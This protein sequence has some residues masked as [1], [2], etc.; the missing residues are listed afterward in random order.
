MDLKAQR[1]AKGFTQQEIAKAVGISRT[2]YTNIENGK[3]KLT[4]K[5]AQKLGMILDV[6]WPRFFENEKVC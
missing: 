5:T 1:I 3:R 6:S 2:A 4:V